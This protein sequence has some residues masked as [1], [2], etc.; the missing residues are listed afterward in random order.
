MAFRKRLKSFG[1]DDITILKQV[2]PVNQAGN[3]YMVRAKE[4]LAGEMVQVILT[5]DDMYEM[6]R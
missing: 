1:Y 2:L 6:M 5:K 3:K 4:P